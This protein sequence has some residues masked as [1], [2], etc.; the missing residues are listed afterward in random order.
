[1]LKQIVFALAALFFSNLIFA[2]QDLTELSRKFDEFSVQK[3]RD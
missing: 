3:K 1:M 2:Q